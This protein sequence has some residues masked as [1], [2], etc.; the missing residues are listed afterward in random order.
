MKKNKKKKSIGEDVN[1]S[2]NPLNQVQDKEAPDEP[3]VFRIAT[4][5]R[6]DFIKQAAKGTV[7]ITGF[8]V[9][10]E[11]LDSCKDKIEIEI[12][13]D[14]NNCNCHVVCTC[15]GEGDSH[16][17]SQGSQ[18]NGGVCTCDTVCICNSVC[19]CDSQGGGGGGGSYYYTYTYW[20]P[21]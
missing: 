19:T 4:K 11:L 21:N 16:N 20:Y 8:A 18:W 3:V 14:K 6:R 1:D 9:L 7:V 13:G 12:Q 10:N 17:V 5:N 15:D 2:T